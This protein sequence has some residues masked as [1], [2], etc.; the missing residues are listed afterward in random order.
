[1]VVCASDRTGAV[2][3]QERRPI[4]ETVSAAARLR[5]EIKSLR[6][7]L[8]QAKLAARIGYTRQ[9][10]SMAER[11]GHNLPSRDLVAAIDAAQ[12]GGGR[13]LSLYEQARQEQRRLRQRN[14][15]GAVP[16]DPGAGSA[17]RRG[18]GRFI[19]AA[20]DALHRDYQAARYHAVEVGLPDV[21]QAVAALCENSSGDQH[22]RALRLRSGVLALRAKLATKL[23]D[24]VAAYA[25]ADKALSS[26]EEAEDAIGRAAAS[27][28]LS[29]AL[30]KLDGIEDAEHNAV[31][32]ADLVRGD[33]PAGLTWR[34]SLTLIAA[35]IAA[36]RADAAEA[37]ARLDHAELLARRLGRDGNIGFSAFGP[38][39]VKI[40]RMSAAVALEDPD[41]VLA[42]G[43][44]LD[45]TAMP[46]GLHGRQGQYHLDNAWAHG[47]RKRDAEAVIHL[48]EAERIA[49]ELLGTSR[50]ARRVLEDLMSRE[51]RQAVPGLR[52]LAG[53]VGVLA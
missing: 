15:V 40:H 6:G 14:R 11:E 1:M 51:R 16:L 10:V 42:L 35:I 5:Q 47:Q 38:T 22:R 48:L 44:Q 9:Y 26:A 50:T 46:E 18:A 8:S 33:D 21:L 53:R 49:P 17:G 3:N 20:L 19:A 28:Q 39:N 29:C 7:G 43:E 37:R 32:S 45:L 34:G 25:A 41:T 13:L 23:G 31:E 4:E 36:R 12:G 24:G 2:M 27:Y 30:L 52:G